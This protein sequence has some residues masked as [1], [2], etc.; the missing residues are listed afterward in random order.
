[1]IPGLGKKYDMEKIKSHLDAMIR[2]LAG[3]S[4]RPSDPKDLRLR[5]AVLILLSATCTIL[6]VFWGI[7]YCSL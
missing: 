4:K 6:G 3:D 7:S 5:K 2:G 1:M